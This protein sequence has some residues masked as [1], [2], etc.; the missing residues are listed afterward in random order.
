MQ[1]GSTKP[2]NRDVGNQSQP[3]VPGAVHVAGTQTAGSATNGTYVFGDTSML[4]SVHKCR[5]KSLLHKTSPVIE[6]K[7]EGI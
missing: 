7:L 3:E 6:V 4:N 2:R 5:D 1:F